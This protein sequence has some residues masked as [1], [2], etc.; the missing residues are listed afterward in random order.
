MN[1]LADMRSASNHLGVVQWHPCSI[2]QENKRHTMIH[3]FPTSFLST[4]FYLESWIVVV[5]LETN[6]LVIKKLR[7]ENPT[8]YI[9]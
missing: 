3:Y 6:K 4:S 9:I 2:C 5:H 8:N 1:L 7:L